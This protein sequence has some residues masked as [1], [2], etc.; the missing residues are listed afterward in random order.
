MP[1]DA[2][3]FEITEQ[4]A[5]GSITDAVS[6]ILELRAMGAEFAVDD[7]GTGYSSL[8][9]LKRL[10]VNFIKIDGAFVQ[11]LTDN[12]ADQTIVR[13]IADIAHI[14]GKA[15]I[16]EFVGDADTLALLGELGVDFAQGFHI[17]K[18]LVDIETVLQQGQ[19]VKLRKRAPATSTKRRSA[20]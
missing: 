19:V 9:Y 4:V 5:I 12:R 10:P 3:I 20:R 15:T 6:Q 16:A 7:F 1:A 18:P 13:A 11:R 2:L 17:G 14:M 8:S